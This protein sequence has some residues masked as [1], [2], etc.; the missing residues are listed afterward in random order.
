M[1]IFWLLSTI[2][3]CFI[4]Y[5]YGNKTGYQDGYEDA[6]YDYP[7]GEFDDEYNT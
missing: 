5:S 4:S 3:A 6:L 2:L 7:E 1:L